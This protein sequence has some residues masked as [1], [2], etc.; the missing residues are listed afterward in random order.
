[1]S[2]RLWQSSRCYVLTCVLCRNSLKLPTAWSNEGRG[3]KEN[4]AVTY[5][6]S[7]LLVVVLLNRHQ[8]GFGFGGGKTLAIKESC[9]ML[10][11]YSFS[12]TAVKIQTPVWLK[13]LSD[14]VKRELGQ[15]AKLSCYQLIYNPTLYELR[16]VTDCSG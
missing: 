8:E 3:L 9:C 13:Y 5:K 10:A 15:K 6:S 1:M 16:V 11:L 2:L 12:H 7:R 14:M 4:L